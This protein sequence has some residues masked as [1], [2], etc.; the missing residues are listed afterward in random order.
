MGINLQNMKA[1]ETAEQVKLFQWAQMQLEYV[2]ELALMFHIPN[3][4]KRSNGA[5]LKAM[6]VK[7]GAPDILLPV[8]AW[9]K[10][11]LAI[12]MKYGDNQLS[13]EQETFLELLQ[14]YNWKTVVCHSFEEAREVI[15]HY[16]SRAVGFDLVNCE[17]AV[18]IEH[19]CLGIDVPWAPCKNCRYYIPSQIGIDLALGKSFLAGVQDGIKNAMEQNEREI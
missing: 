4:G 11:G 2:P 17:E 10:T 3:E 1:G 5:L 15:R 12:E 18:K 13:K 14:E 7:R 8:P 16:L 9:E 6:G 19:H